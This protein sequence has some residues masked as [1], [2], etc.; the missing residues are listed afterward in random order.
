MF[1][2]PGAT[3]AAR[4]AVLGPGGA[5]NRSPVHHQPLIHFVSN[6]SI[7][8]LVLVLPVLLFSCVEAGTSP[9]RVSIDAGGPYRATFSEPDI[10]F[11]ARVVRDPGNAI[12][13]FHWDFG[14]N[15][16]IQQG[17][18][19]RYRYLPVDDENEN[20]ADAADGRVRVFQVTVTAR[21]S[22]GRFLARARTVAELYRGRAVD[23][24]LE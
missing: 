19:V 22:G 20:D 14:V 5:M 16:E 9:P 3:A 2:V 13:S 18:P 7:A 10:T 1:V 11:T 4:H 17:N 15:D 8:L 12:A 21:D 23:V 24:T 6:A